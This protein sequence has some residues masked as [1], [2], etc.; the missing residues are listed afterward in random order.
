MQLPPRAAAMS[1][2]FP[3]GEGAVDFQHHVRAAPVTRDLIVLPGWPYVIIVDKSGIRLELHAC[4]R[5]DAPHQPVFVRNKRDG[6]HRN[7]LGC[8][9]AQA[10]ARAP[11]RMYVMR[12]TGNWA[13]NIVALC[14]TLQQP[15][16]VH[17]G[18][19]VTLKE[20]IKFIILDGPL[21]EQAC[22]QRQAVA[23]VGAGA[24][25]QVGLAVRRRMATIA[26]YEDEIDIV[27]SVHIRPRC[28]TCVAPCCILVAGKN[29]D[30]QLDSFHVYFLKM[31]ASTADVKLHVA[32]GAGPPVPVYTARGSYSSS[33][34]SLGSMP[35]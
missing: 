21:A 15:V 10:V 5:Q 25:K 30:E 11:A 33:A 34:L 29:A 8:L 9:A 18:V 19:V 4:I 14:A 24:M 12:A 23:V 6:G 17:V 31:I 22:F 35:W 2:S 3:P 28:Q 7:V 27:P 32:F 20:K 26:E 1:I 16:D 13:A